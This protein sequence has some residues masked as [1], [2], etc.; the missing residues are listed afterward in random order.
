MKLSHLD[1]A[2]ALLEKANID[3]EPE[4]LS[5]DAAREFLDR[6]ARAKKLA[7]FGET[8]LMRKVDDAGE[9][10]R[11]TG[12]SIGKAKATVETAKTLRDAE[13]V[14]E[15]FAGGELSLDQAS[16]I[17]RAEQAKPGAAKELLTVAKEQSFQVLREKS[18]KVVLEAE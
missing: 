13:T 15:A 4:L 3:L 17:A 1:D 6:Y 5:T 16:E 11:V 2:I 12:T 9:I 10:A 18:R 8:A 14:S 7:A